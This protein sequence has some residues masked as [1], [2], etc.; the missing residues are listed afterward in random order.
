MPE[1]MGGFPY[2]Q[3]EFDEDGKP[4]QPSAVDTLLGELS[5]QA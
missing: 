2:W 1:Q 5:A 3:I 4:V